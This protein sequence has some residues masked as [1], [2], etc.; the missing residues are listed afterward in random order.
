LATRVAI[1]GFGR[2]GRNIVRA[3]RGNDAFEIVAANDIAT[4]AVLAHLLQ[5]D[6]ILGRYPGEV[7][8]ND[9]AI[10]VDGKEIEIFSAKAPGD[11]DWGQL[12]VDIVI[13]SSGLFVNAEQAGAH[14]GRGHAR[15]VIITAPAKGEDIT[16]CMGVND[17]EYR[18]AEHHVIS[19]ASCTTNCL[20]PVAKVIHES[21]GIESGLMTT[22][23]AYTGDQRLLDAPHKDPRRSR[24]AA[25][26][27]I[28]TTSGAAE[29]VARVVPSLAG[30]FKGFSLRVP[31]PDVSMVDFSVSTSRPT[32][33]EAVN[34]A[35]REAA[36]GSLRGILRVE[37]G[38]LVS[39]DFRGDPSSSIV[40]AP[41]TV[42][43][44]DH[45]LKVLSWYDNEWGYS[46]RV[47]DLTALVATSLPKGPAS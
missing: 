29:A 6:S 3:A 26:S 10:L 15:K 22:V 47:C 40:D 35:L 45:H 27:L 46:C 16:V 12:G 38:T 24:A 7:G 4:P 33:A 8:S 30:K 32:T 31:V 44:S 5:Y 14:I 20:A 21:F 36:A 42:M 28:P 23:H 39:I 25:L 18:P 41:L 17:A 2:I 1:N 34:D 37:E 11:I 19:N 13:E 9:S 43:A